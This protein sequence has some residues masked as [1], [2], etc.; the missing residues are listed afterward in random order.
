MSNLPIPT[1]QS[2]FHQN[3]GYHSP[4]IRVE[5]GGVRTCVPK[6]LQGLGAATGVEE[7]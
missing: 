7:G 6:A 5:V 3:T 2:V 4:C 1:P